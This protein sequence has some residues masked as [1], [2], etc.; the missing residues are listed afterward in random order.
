MVE[1][2]NE[3]ARLLED[4]REKIA[5]SYG[6]VCPNLVSLH[7]LSVRHRE[8]RALL[9]DVAGEPLSIGADQAYAQHLRMAS[10]S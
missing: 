6:R 7:G 3:Y 2:V 1:Q 8:R 5:A 9:Q 10:G 4:D